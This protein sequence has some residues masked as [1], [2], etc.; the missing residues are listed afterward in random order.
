[1]NFTYRTG[2]AGYLRRK[3][4][5]EGEDASMPVELRK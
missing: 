5:A 4:D 1:M 3:I 2:P